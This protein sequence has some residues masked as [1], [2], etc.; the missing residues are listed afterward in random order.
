M[1]ILIL[2]FR[3]ES[4]IKEHEQHCFRDCLMTEI[5]NGL[6]INFIDLVNE[7]IPHFE[8]FK[9]QYTGIILG[10]SSLYL[11]SARQ[12]SQ[13]KYILKKTKSLINNLIIN[14][15][16]TLGICFGAQLLA[17]FLN[18][19]I[20]DD[21]RF[22]ERGTYEINLSIY[23][24]KHSLFKSLPHTFKV[25]EGHLESLT[26]INQGK[27][28]ATGTNNQINT[29][30]IKQNILGTIFHPELNKQRQLERAKFYLKGKLL[31]E[32]VSKRLQDSEN[33][34][35]IIINWIK[36]LSNSN[37]GSSPE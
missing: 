7:K 34:D 4:K 17:F 1:K 6:E 9:N 20:V 13:S 15:F 22:A 21:P 24:Q 35:Q 27:V 30:Q 2:Q 16:P 37:P 3:P 33:A 8:K 29:F 26:K 19:K 31:E 12:N 25:Q 32:F 36:L 11:S 28:L 5:N 23:G 14:D 10:G 18:N